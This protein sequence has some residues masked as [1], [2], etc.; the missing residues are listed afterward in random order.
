[1]SKKPRDG[2][3]GP[4][5]AEKLEALSRALNYYTTRLKNQSQWQK[6]YI[7]A[8]AGPGLSEVRSKPREDVGQSLQ[9]F[10]DQSTDP[11]E[12][13]VVFLRGSPRV[14]L[15]IA[16]PFDRYVFVD[17]DP[18]RVAELEGIRSEYQSRRTIEIHQGDANSILQELLK[19]ISKAR[20]R[21]YIFLDPFGLQMTWGTIEA[22]ARTGAIEVI[23]NFPLGMALRRIMPNSGNVPAGWQISLDTFFGSP[24]W[25][26]HAYEER[27]DLLGKRTSKIA[28]SEDRL[29]AWY[30]GRLKDVFGHVSEAQL[31]TNMRGGRLYYL[32]WAGPHEAGLEGANYILTMKTRLP[33]AKKQTKS[34]ST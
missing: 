11:V 14:A 34:P 10:T 31:V 19:S 29:L 16:N 28:D 27:V 3:V 8:F 9:L 15:D 26:Q 5:A 23:V 13:E 4:W 20:H 6:I 33:K 22:I 17:K 25:R 18:D 24:D 21:A 1:M 2:S 12:Q 32:I 7:D 30:R